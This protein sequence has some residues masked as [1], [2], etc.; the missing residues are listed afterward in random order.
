MPCAFQGVFRDLYVLPQERMK[1]TSIRFPDRSGGTSNANCR[2]IMNEASTTPISRPERRDLE[3]Q[4]SINHERG[5]HRP[6]FPTGVEGPRMPTTHQMSGR[7]SAWEVRPAFTIVLHMQQTRYYIYIAASIRRTLY[8]GMTRDISDRMQ[9]HKAGRVAGFSA[10]YRTNQLVW[11]EVA[12]SFEA[13][14]EREAQI[15]RWR[16][17]KKLS[18]IENGN[19]HWI[20]LSDQVE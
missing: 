2:S 1:S 20:D 14:R 17:S 7:T 3:C 8:T 11:C 9:Q 18:L 19:P 6:D 15:K 13:A 10:K 12:E 5:Q 16:R 4:L